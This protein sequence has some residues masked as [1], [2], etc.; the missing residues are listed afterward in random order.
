MNLVMVRGLRMC[1]PFYIS[2][3]FP[4]QNLVIGLAGLN[5]VLATDVFI[6][7]LS[8]PPFCVFS[9]AWLTGSVMIS[10]FLWFVANWISGSL[11]LYFAYIFFIVYLLDLVILLLPPLPFFICL[12]HSF[13]QTLLV[14]SHTALSYHP[15][16]PTFIPLLSFLTHLSAPPIACLKLT[17]LTLF[18]SHPLAPPHTH[19]SHLQLHKQ[20]QHHRPHGSLHHPLRSHNTSAPPNEAA[21][22]NTITLAGP[23]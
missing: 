6:L 12:I 11:A 18:L 16:L 14:L 17:S 4:I 21:H 9:L 7:I 10:F 8:S 2:T 19:G 3:H 13:Q 22:R 1:F 20:V 15:T 5:D 23:N